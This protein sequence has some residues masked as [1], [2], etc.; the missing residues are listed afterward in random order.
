MLAVWYNRGWTMQL[1]VTLVE[2]IIALVIFSILIA[3]GA[4]NFM[5]WIQSG[6]V[7]T[8]SESIVNGLQRAR[9][10]AVTR[11]SWA[12][13]YL[14]AGSGPGDS[15]WAVLAASAPASAQ[16]CPGT[17]VA[18]YELVDSHP[19][20]D[21]SP[22]VTVKVTQHSAAYN[23]LTQPIT[24]DNFG[25]PFPVQP[26]E[27]DFDVSS[28]KASC[29]ANGGP[30]RCMRIVVATGGQARMCNPAYNYANNPQ[31]C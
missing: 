26:Y 4:P 29:M 15:T 3:V 21:G 16:P 2:L 27:I 22:N 19:A 25:R 13:F 12:R 6:Q 1:G 20:S 5:T 30:I 23:A 28:S 18:G 8:A 7:R 17:T 10:E 24:F 9:A 14:C 31:G 11:N